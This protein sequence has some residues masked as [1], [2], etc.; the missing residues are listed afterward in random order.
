MRRALWASLVIVFGWA[1]FAHAQTPGQADDVLATA[2]NGAPILHPLTKRTVAVK[3]SSKTLQVPEMMVY[4]ADGPF[5][6]GS[7]GEEETVTLPAYCIGK[8]SVTNAEYQA[9]LDVTGSRN[10]PRHWRDGKFPKNKA[11]HP[12]VYVSLDDAKAY[13]GWVAKNTGADVR[14]PTSQ[15]WEKAARGPQGFLY[16][17]GNEPGSRFQNGALETKFRYN[18]V[19][20]TYYL[21]KE[22][23]RAVT[24]DNPKSTY[25]GKQTTVDG[26]AGYDRN[27]NANPLS[28]SPTGSVRGWVNHDTWTGFIYT[29]LFTSLNNSGGDTSAVGTY[30]QG[31][32]AYGCYDMAG[33]V[34]N[35]CDTLI[36]ANNGAERGR[37]VNDIRGGSWYAN[38]TSCK[39]IGMGEGRSARG[40]Y[41]TVGFRIVMLPKA[42]K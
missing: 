7:G 8:F 11:A 1:S 42:E 24:Y 4:V 36:T 6:F 18:A 16:P 34:W 2:G 3:Q 23:K 35:W 33:N 17:W 20:A 22:P 31:K 25:L 38:G 10:F 14:I 13:A 29:D 27:G 19:T 26:I 28:V 40:A 30:E 12:V 37:E 15:Q 32:S 21:T 9:F 39:S 41:N 5:S